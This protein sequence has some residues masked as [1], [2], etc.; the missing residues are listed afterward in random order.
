MSEPSEQ[1]QRLTA[2]ILNLL[3]TVKKQ[4]KQ[5]KAVKG[6]QARIGKRARRTAPPPS[7]AAATTLIVENI[8]AEIVRETDKKIDLLEDLHKRE[9]RELK[10]AYEQ[11]LDDYRRKTYAPPLPQDD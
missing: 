4:D 8:L 6:L 3:E 9:M 5:P 7:L 2:A 11:K 10:A 1:H